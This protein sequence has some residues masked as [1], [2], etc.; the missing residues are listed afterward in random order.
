MIRAIC[1]MLGVS[2]YD[3][4][5]YVEFALNSTVSATTGFAPFETWYGENVQLPIDHAL[6]TPP[7][8]D[9]DAP[10]FVANIRRI[11][12]ETQ[13]AMQ[14][15]QSYQKRYYDAHHTPK[16][17]QVNDYVL[18]STSNMRLRGSR[19]LLPRFAGPFQVLARIGTQAYKLR[20]PEDWTIHPTFH[21]SLLRQAPMTSL[22][23]GRATPYAPPDQAEA[24]FSDSD[25]AVGNDETT[26][27]A[28]TLYRLTVILSVN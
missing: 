16:Q 13:Q 7:H 6:H 12:S 15:A 5:P 9:R 17:F 23:D 22:S 14:R 18:L 20:L 11:V 3:A 26:N 21:V 10:N 28:A 1:M 25:D 4:I 24:D 2:W 19:K 8:A 27:T